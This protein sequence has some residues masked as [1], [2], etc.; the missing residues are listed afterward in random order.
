MGLQPRLHSLTQ[1][2]YLYC[3]PMSFQQV[4]PVNG[5]RSQVTNILH[6]TPVEAED[7]NK[8]SHSVC[9]RDTRFNDFSANASGSSI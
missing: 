4:D 5:P 6:S 9:Q 3:R 1:V 7:Q 2:G 8:V